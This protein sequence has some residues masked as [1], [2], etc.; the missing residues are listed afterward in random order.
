MTGCS[1]NESG[2]RTLSAIRSQAVAGPAIL[3]LRRMRNRMTSLAASWQRQHLAM[4]IWTIMEDIYI[5]IHMYIYVYPW[6]GVWNV[7]LPIFN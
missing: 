4:H 5:Y 7:I 6:A 1:A 2:S 3:A